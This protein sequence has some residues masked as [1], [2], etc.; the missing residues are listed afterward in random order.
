MAFDRKRQSLIVYIRLHRRADLTD[1]FVAIRVADFG[2]MG[3]ER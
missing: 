1:H 2:Y 3:C